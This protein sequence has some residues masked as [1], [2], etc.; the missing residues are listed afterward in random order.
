MSK[1]YLDRTKFRFQLKLKKMSISDICE[2]MNL[3]RHTFNNW[4]RG[5]TTQ[6]NIMLL[7]HYLE[8]TVDDLI[9]E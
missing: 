6:D 5:G 2:K 1:L 4:I 9:T 7:A 8:C 3:T